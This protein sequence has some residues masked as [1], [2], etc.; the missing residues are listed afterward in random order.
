[1]S[2]RCE[3]AEEGTVASGTTPVGDC[4]GKKGSSEFLQMKTAAE[5]KVERQTQIDNGD[6]A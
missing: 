3:T 6:G 2:Y 5:C 4:K 1:L